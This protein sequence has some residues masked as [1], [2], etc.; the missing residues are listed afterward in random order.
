MNIRKIA[1]VGSFAAGVALAFSPLAVADDLTSSV[2]S[3]ISSLNALFQADAEIAGV[4]TS[5]Y[6]LDSGGFDVI[7]KGDIASVTPST[8]PFSP[9]DYQLFGSNPGEAVVSSDPGSYDVLNG[10]L[11]EFDDAYNAAL[12]SLLN[13]SNVIP[14]GD[15]F[16]SSTTIDA[17]LATGSDAGAFTTFFDAG[18]GDLEGFFGIFR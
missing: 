6:S 14:V 5:D 4:P 2:D 3:E 13:D 8:A 18:L 7:D 15:L 17:A 1:A 11:T 16:G 12:Y 10:A 9:L